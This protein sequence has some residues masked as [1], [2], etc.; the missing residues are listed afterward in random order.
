MLIFNDTRTESINTLIVDVYLMIMISEII[1]IVA[2]VVMM[3]AG[4][5]LLAVTDKLLNYLC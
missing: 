3:F 1:S 2:I 4:L 5:G